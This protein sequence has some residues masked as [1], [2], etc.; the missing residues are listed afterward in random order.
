M[1]N[2]KG[3][4]YFNFIVKL[5]LTCM[6]MSKPTALFYSVL[7]KLRQFI[8][9]CQ[10]NTI[11]HVLL[12]WCCKCVKTE[13]IQLKHKW[14][15]NCSIFLPP[16]ALLASVHLWV[17]HVSVHGRKEGESQFGV[18]FRPLEGSQHPHVPR[19]YVLHIGPD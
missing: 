19:I 12:L 8:C 13:H 10:V 5:F 7:C 6:I 9:W 2:K 18:R 11:T 4:F 3:T 16:V 15:E 1:W 17:V 14:T